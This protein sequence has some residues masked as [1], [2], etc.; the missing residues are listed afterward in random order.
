MEGEEK[1]LKNEFYEFINKTKPKL[2]LKRKI[3]SE[4]KDR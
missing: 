2:K 3:S 1:K 4:V